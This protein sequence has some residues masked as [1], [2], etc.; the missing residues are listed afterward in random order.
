MKSGFFRRHIFATIL[1]AIAVVGVGVFAFI[2]LRDP[3]IE[4]A[5]QVPIISDLEILTDD[6]A[7]PLES[8]AIPTPAPSPAP[9]PV[10][11]ATPIPSPTPTPTAVPTATP[12][13]TV[14]PLPLAAV[15]ASLAPSESSG[16]PGAEISIA[17]YNFPPNEL[18][19]D[20]W[21]GGLNVTPALP[22]TTDATG[23]IN[24]YITV[25]ELT[26]DN[27]SIRATV[28]SV[29]AEAP[30]SVT[31]GPTPTP[32]TTLRPTA[33][34][35]PTPRPSP[36]PAPTSTP[37]A[38]PTP[39]PTPV[40]L[41]LG[42]AQYANAHYTISVPQ[43]W[44][45]GRVTF[46]ARAHSGSPALWFQYNT[47]P[48]ARRYDIMPLEKL[49]IP[50]VGT[51]FKERYSDEGLC[52]DRGFVVIRESALVWDWREAGIALQV[53]VCEADLPLE[54]EPGIT[55]EA[56]SAKIIRSLRQQN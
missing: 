6:S 34:P 22:A 5:A 8:L 43:R 37:T 26:P 53:D 11:T 18:L 31:P 56:V 45:G 54:A 44:P 4:L 48:G 12:V 51:Y 42:H 16:S 3:V 20:V 7:G 39:A 30:L 32:R 40:P 2:F 38:T 17:G 19:T 25:P 35:T 52:G 23:Y 9:K 10:P 41:V 36:T 13:P 15:E 55:N 1:V 28:G 24:F 21:L 29:M 49:G 50:L 27:H 46:N 14:T 47:I 33:T